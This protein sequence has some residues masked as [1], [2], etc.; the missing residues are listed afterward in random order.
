[1]ALLSRRPRTLSEPARTDARAALAETIAE[2]S[3]VIATREAAKVALSTARAAVWRTQADFETAEDELRRARDAV[4]SYSAAM[5]A[6]RPATPPVPVSVARRAMEAAEDAR[7]V[8]IAEFE[9]IKGAADGPVL[10]PEM[11][12]DSA[13]IAVLHAEAGPIAE[14]VAA[15]CLRLQRELVRHGVLFRW[16]H[17]QGFFDRATHREIIADPALSKLQ[18][19]LSNAFQSSGS[20]WH[21]IAAQAGTSAPWDAF[22][23][24]LATDATAPLPAP[25]TPGEAR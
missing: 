7:D 16:F 22:L 14:Q 5:A 17:S 25:I 8:A 20:G 2:T 1:M 23:A 9:R 21:T 18:N 10:P 6:N 13:V 3:A 24:A 12:R 15:E 19:D 11:K 4:A